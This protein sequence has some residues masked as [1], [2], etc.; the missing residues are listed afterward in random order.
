MEKIGFVVEATQ[1]DR[2]GA[3]VRRVAHAQCVGAQRRDPG[4]G[5]L[6]AARADRGD[7]WGGGN[8]CRDR[9]NLCGLRKRD[10]YTAATTG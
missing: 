9:M 4:G 10:V 8:I 2:P 1:R 6:R 5:D 3:R 7:R